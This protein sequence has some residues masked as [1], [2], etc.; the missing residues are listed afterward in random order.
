MLPE[1]KHHRECS[2]ALRLPSALFWACCLFVQ[3]PRVCSDFFT[4]KRASRS[5]FCESRVYRPG[6]IQAQIFAFSLILFWKLID[7]L[8]YSI[9][10]NLA[11]C[12]LFSL[13]CRLFRAPYVKS[14]QAGGGVVGTLY[15]KI[16]PLFTFSLFRYWEILSIFLISTAYEEVLAPFYQLKSVKS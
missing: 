14:E 8:L 5:R 12:I 11:R 16:F 1:M 6:T 9:K 2:E 3:T 13:S 10:R 7:L 15:P 4:F